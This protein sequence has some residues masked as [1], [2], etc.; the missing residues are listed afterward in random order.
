ME[1]PNFLIEMSKQMNNEDVRCTAEPIWTVC[2]DEWLSCADDRG[3]KTILLLCDNG[4][5]YIECD[6]TD[7]T[8]IFEYLKEY[9]PIW[10]MAL[11]HEF[12]E[13]EDDI[14]EL[15]SY[16]EL[17]E[18]IELPDE[19]TIEKLDMQKHRKIVKSCLTEEDARYFIKRKQHDYAPLYTYVES[20]I[21]CPQMIELRAWIKS[22]TKDN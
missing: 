17:D 11:I 5:H 9:H 19:L 13:E 12:D 8:E 16:L 18:Y 15:S 4:D 22:I 1:I 10:S 3:D 2:Y 6:D 21:F 20:M 7:H 14:D